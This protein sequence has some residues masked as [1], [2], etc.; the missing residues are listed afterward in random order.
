[1][2][3]LDKYY[4]KSSPLYNDI[5]YTLASENG[6]DKPLKD[7][8]DDYKKNNISICEEGCDFTQ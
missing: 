4:N 7:R 8:Q 1:M 6:L 3:S 2:K 5:C